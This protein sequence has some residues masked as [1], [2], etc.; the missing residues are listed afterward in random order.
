MPPGVPGACSFPRE[1]GVL[2]KDER[3]IPRGPVL[4]PLIGPVLIF[5]LAVYLYILAGKH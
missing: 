5:L 2:G 3:A 4:K 1:K